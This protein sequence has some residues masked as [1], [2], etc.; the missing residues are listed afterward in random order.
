MLFIW[1]SDILRVWCEPG[2]IEME[3]QLFR[4]L[5]ATPDLIRSSDGRD[6]VPVDHTG[7]QL[8][9]A[10]QADLL[11]TVEPVDYTKAAALPEGFAPLGFSPPFLVP[12]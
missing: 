8:G 4:L 2:A 5:S 1:R 6:I 3:N 9:D 11:I 10:A 7:A 12:S